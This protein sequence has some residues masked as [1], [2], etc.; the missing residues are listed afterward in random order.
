MPD[1]DRA[2]NIGIVGCGEV[3]GQ[4]HLR[5]LLA[6][7]DARVVALA[8][9]DRQRLEQVADRYGIAHR[10]PNIFALLE[11]LELD[12]VG[13][14]VPAYARAEVAVAAIKAGKHVYL[15]KP[16]ALSLEDA[17]RIVQ[18]ASGR[19]QKYLMGFH[20]RWHRLIRE[21]RMLVANGSVGSIETVR[22]LWF[23]PRQN[24]GL[25]SW[26]NR[27][28][29]GGGALVEI[30]VHCFDLWRHLA[31]AE[32]EQIF[33]AARD[34]TRNDEVAAVTARMSNG[35]LT[36]GVFSE[37][38][39]HEIEAEICGAAGRLRV[40]CQRFDGLEFFPAGSAPGRLSLHLR[41]M[42]RFLSDLPAGLRGMRNGG[43][44]LDSYRGA[45][46]HFCGVIRN[47]GEVECTIED[48]RRA[49]AIAL[50]AVE[51]AST[52]LSVR[53]PN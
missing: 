29:S 2:V 25:P 37:R 9:S 44:Y 16:L 5:A 42:S 4:K 28:A 18:A 19:P 36:V 45:W 13:V 23:S 46:R 1:R 35:A 12:A 39:S 34:G 10:Y 22:T 3:T 20:M 17:N 15:E 6:V 27:R 47:G 14:C 41:R 24:E 11:H 21:A 53:V 30:G 8:D 26:R 50:A 48:G 40:G 49:L 43:D 51:S 52:G 31:S 33:A 32:V 7:P 38:T